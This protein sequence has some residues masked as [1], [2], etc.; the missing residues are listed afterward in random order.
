MSR[1]N[2][3]I[4]ARQWLEPV[5]CGVVGELY[6]GGESLK[7][8][9]RA[10]AGA[11]PKHICEKSFFRRSGERLYRTGDVGRR[12]NRWQSEYLGR[13]DG[14]LILKW[15]RVEAGAIEAAW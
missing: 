3:V 11:D 15:H 6:V 9:L 10:A 14:R 13:R 1:R 12:R 8:G 4:P 5:P 7:F 2:E